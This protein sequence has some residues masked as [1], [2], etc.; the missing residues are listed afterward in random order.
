[1]FPL[2]SEKI[3]DVDYVELNKKNVH[4]PNECLSWAIVH[5]KHIFLKNFIRINLTDHT[6]ITFNTCGLIFLPSQNIHTFS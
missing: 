6:A 4:S 5:L 3:T 2:L 1:M